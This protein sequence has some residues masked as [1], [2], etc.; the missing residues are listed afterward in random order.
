[1]TSPSSADPTPVSLKGDAQALTICWSDGRTHT[2]PWTRLRENCPCAGC[3]I[4]RAEPP[5]MFAILK[6]EELQP[7]RA[8]GMRPLGN[9]AYHID[10]SDGHNTGIFSL[11]LLRALGDASP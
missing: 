7:V 2:L 5:P 4:K 9:Y 3:R 11:E 10:F 8:T 1:M 6:P